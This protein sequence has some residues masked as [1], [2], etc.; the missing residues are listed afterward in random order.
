MMRTR[1]RDRER[2]IAMAM[3]KMDHRTIRGLFARFD[4]SKNAAEKRRVIAGALKELKIHAAIEEQIFY[5]AVRLEA[6]DSAGLMEQ[7]DEEHHEVKLLIAELARMTGR[8]ANFFAKFTVLRDNVCHHIEKEEGEM[9]PRASRTGINFEA[10]GE[11]MGELKMR[12]CEN[13]V[14]QDAESVMVNGAGLPGESP[15]KKA[16]KTIDVPLWG[17]RRPWLSPLGARRRS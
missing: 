7:A 4:G 10:L 17:R 15:A 13:G 11:R 14:P 2:S 6:G 12:L 3:L 1:L 16:L 8:E 5:P 9:M